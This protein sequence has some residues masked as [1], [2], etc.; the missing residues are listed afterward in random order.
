M[1]KE[2]GHRKTGEEQDREKEVAG[3]NSALPTP[4]SDTPEV[5]PPVPVDD[6]PG[7]GEDI[8]RDPGWQDR[9]QELNSQAWKKGSELAQKTARELK[10]KKQLGGTRAEKE[11]NI[12]RL[13]QQVIDFCRERETEPD[14]LRASLQGIAD[15]EARIRTKE[16]ELESLDGERGDGLSFWNRV[17]KTLS[18]YAGYTRCKLDISLARN[19]LESK[20]ASLGQFVYS[21][22][23]SLQE[24]LRDSRGIVELFERIEQQEKRIEYL[25]EQIHELE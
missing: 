19:E 15:V 18:R 2:T 25:E 4:V 8:S 6:P 24:I 21:R 16:L 10:L 5:H 23:Q 12:K 13:G 14:E 7:D 11:L 22:R 17:K 3:T 20:T 9:L 1:Q